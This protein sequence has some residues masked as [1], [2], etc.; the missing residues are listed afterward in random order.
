MPLSKKTLDEIEKTKTSIEAICEGK[1]NDSEILSEKDLFDC[2]LG[3]N[4]HYHLTEEIIP[5]N[6]FDRNN[7][8]SNNQKEIVKY[9]QKKLG[10]YAA[11]PKKGTVTAIRNT[12]VFNH[13]GM[14]T[15]NSWNLANY[16]LKSKNNFIKHLIKMAKEVRKTLL[17]NNCSKKGLTDTATEKLHSLQTKTVILGER[18]IGKTTFIN[19]LI[20]VDG[21]NESYDGFDANKVILVRIDLNKKVDRDLSLLDWLEYQIC[22]IIYNYYQMDSKDYHGRKWG[23]NFSED[24]VDLKK[25]LLKTYSSEPNPKKRFEIFIEGLSLTSGHRGT[26]TK[27]PSGCFDI[28][29]KYLTNEEEVSFLLII[30]GLD[31]LALDADHQDRFKKRIEELQSI[32]QEH[33]LTGAFLVV[34]R[35]STYDQYLSGL[36]FNRKPQ[37]YYIEKVD[38]EKIFQA[39][40][41]HLSREKVLEPERGLLKALNTNSLKE[42]SIVLK[43]LCEELS[44]FIAFGLDDNLLT[45]PR[46]KS[47]K[48]TPFKFLKKFFGGNNRAIFEAISNFISFAMKY[49]GDEFAQEII[50]SGARS[51]L[52][53]ELKRRHY[54]V[55]EALLLG[56][57]SPFY[58]S[59]YFYTFSKEKISRGKGR[60]NSLIMNVFNFPILDTPKEKIQNLS[61]VGVRALQ[62]LQ[63]NSD[64]RTYDIV[65]FICNHFKYEENLVISVVEELKFNNFIIHP[66]ESNWLRISPI[67]E[68]VINE[69]VYNPVYL[70]FVTQSTPLFFKDL[71]NKTFSLKKIQDPVF[72]AHQI[73]NAANF[74]RYLKK[75]ETVEQELFLNNRTEEEEQKNWTFRAYDD[76]DFSITKK[77]NPSGVNILSQRIVSLAERILTGASKR[78]NQQLY[79]EF[80]N[81]FQ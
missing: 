73:K 78:S 62:Y 59:H 81:I 19:Y 29:Y 61:T 66:Q 57:E 45:T 14:P 23:F 71:K 11:S 28:L 54:I 77:Q 15:E 32:F 67:G 6:E 80:L 49:Y 20:S 12:Y 72:A 39:K 10:H 64:S 5:E 9:L 65:N 16:S 26:P 53:S 70:G 18:G 43:I 30:D 58:H 69:L 35:T 37:K 55:L 68:F 34:L 7:N 76:Y 1:L 24:N 4:T 38:P 36:P 47:K 25:Y 60:P 41:H 31:L 27:L 21:S 44:H 33:N 51:K 75:I 17:A 50:E 42:A 40:I 56:G 22:R 3:R 74:A 2:N 46:D 13:S 8:H 79:N 48:E 63:I 52:S